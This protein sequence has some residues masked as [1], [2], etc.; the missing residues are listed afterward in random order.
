MFSA[1]S[2]CFKIPELRQRILFTLAVIVIARV[3]AAIPV[4]GVNSTILGMFFESVVDQQAQ[5]SV[6]GLFN[7]FSG[8]ALENCAIFSLSVMPYITASIMMQL[9]TAIVPSLGKLSREEGGRQK[10]TQYSRLLT[11]VFCVFQGYLLAIGFEKPESIPLLKGIQ[12]IILREGTPLVSDSGPLFRFTTILSLTTGTMLLMW[13]GEQIT[14]KGI[15]NGISIII[16]VGILAQL[17]AALIQAWNKITAGSVVTSPLLVVALLGFLFAV[18]A[19]TV[20][21]TQAIRKVTVQ[22]AKQI[23][24]NKIFGGQS[25]YLPL[26]LNYAGVMPVIFAQSIIL[27][28]STVLSIIP[29]MPIGIQQ[30]I[31]NL[32]HGWMYYVLYGLMIFFFSYFW[33]AMVFN[34]VQIAEDLKK[35]NGAI[36]GVRPG[37]GTAMFLDHAMTRL[38]FAGAVFLAFIAILPL[39]IHHNLKIPNVTA[40]FFGGT[41]L[42][43]VVGVVLDVMRQ[44]ETYLLQRHYDGFLKKGRIRGRSAF[45]ATTQSR[46]VDDTT[47]VWIYA[48]I[49]ILVIAGITIALSSK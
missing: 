17:P 9:L 49:G 3:G 6:I 44:M 47:L 19:A 41:S 4:P 18:I 22:Y 46:T 45:Q 30:F 27:F 39:I 1:F 23:R 38:T 37:E 8:G 21:I 36:P 32:T 42:L 15:G 16:T 12:E 20:A 28:P 7:L 5:G 35:N 26:K 25:S 40:Q 14:D 24:G 29:N 33:V 43:I 34:P 2:N 11:L 31:N 13:L 48:L 10:I